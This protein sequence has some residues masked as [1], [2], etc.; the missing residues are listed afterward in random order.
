M[1]YTE[2]PTTIRYILDTNYID[3]GESK[4]ISNDHVRL[5]PQQFRTIRIFPKGTR[6][7][8][9]INVTSGQKYLIRASFGYGNYDGENNLPEFE[10][11]LGD[12]LWDSVVFTCDLVNS[13]IAKELIH[14]PVRNYIH[15]CLVDINKG[16]PFISV[17]ELRP[18]RDEIYQSEVGSLALIQRCDTGRMVFS[19]EIYLFRYPDDVLDRLWYR[20]DEGGWKQL[21]TSSVIDMDAVYQLPSRVMSTAATPNDISS[22]Y[23]NFSFTPVIEVEEYSA[24]WSREL[25]ITMDGKLISTPFDPHYLRTTTTN[26]TF[27]AEGGKYYFSISTPGTTY[28]PILNAFEIYM[29]KEFL[30]S[31]TNQ[32]DAITN[33]KST[34]K[35][36]KNWQGDPCN[37]Q[38]Y[39]WEGVKC[40]YSD[41]DSARIIS[42]DLSQSGLTGEIAASIAN[43]TM[44]QTLDLSNNN[45]SGQIPEYLSQLPKLNV[46]NLEKNELTGSVPAGLIA[47]GKDGLSLSLCG[48]PSLSKQV[49]CEKKKNKFA[50][51][52]VVSIIVM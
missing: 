3:T 36:I 34:Y 47:K 16:V 10:L 37:P 27:T 41:N 25:T 22:K 11:C 20:C 13:I 52:V 35:I 15:I 46:L 6:N 28:Q 23:L 24:S 44:I 21:S 14:I 1:G 2:G 19:D 18:L 30:V 50:V 43:L 49:P 42:L 7:C 32:Q 26:T 29:A 17:I 5:L 39:L 45:L 12:S 51:P 9:K 33:L 40:S 8:Y 31:E 4:T 38:V 48:N